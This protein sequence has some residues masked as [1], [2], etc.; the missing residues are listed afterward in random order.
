VVGAV[1]ILMS[2]RTVEDRLRFL[3]EDIVMVI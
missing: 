1:V 2:G 3:S